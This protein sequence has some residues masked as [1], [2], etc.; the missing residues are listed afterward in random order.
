MVKV[1]VHIPHAFESDT[2]NI[3]IDFSHKSAGMLQVSVK[4]KRMTCCSVKFF[5]TLAVTAGITNSPSLF[6]LLYFLL[7]SDI[8]SEGSIAIVKKFDFGFFL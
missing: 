8:R 1:T 6:T 4:V 5:P 2:S 3:V 7:S